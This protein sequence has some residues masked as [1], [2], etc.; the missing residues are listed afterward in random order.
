MGLYD[1]PE[2][3]RNLLNGF[4]QGAM[5]PAMGPVVGGAARMAA[6]YLQSGAA[7]AANMAGTLP[8]YMGMGVGDASSPAG[9]QGQ[10][11]ALPQAA[12]QAPA[13]APT[14][15]PPAPRT[16]QTMRIWNG[17][18]QTKATFNEAP[19]PY[20]QASPWWHISQLQDGGGRTLADPQSQGDIN[21]FVK[22]SI[23]EAQQQQNK[24][25][26]GNPHVPTTNAL[27]QALSRT[28]RYTG[29]YSPEDMQR[30]LQAQEKLLHGQAEQTKAEAAQTAAGKE[31]TAEERLIGGTYNTPG[32]S[33][34]ES[35]QLLK[36]IRAE[37]AAAKKGGG[38]ADTQTAPVLPGTGKGPPS[39]TNEEDINKLITD[40]PKQPTEESRKAILASAGAAPG[41]TFDIDSLLK[42]LPGNE[43]VTERGMSPLVT[44]LLNSTAVGG[45]DA[46][47]TAAQ[48]AMIRRMNALKLKQYGRFSLDDPRSVPFPAHNISPE[49]HHTLH[50]PA[51]DFTASEPALSAIIPG[52]SRITDRF[53]LWSPKTRQEY[54]SQLGPLNAILEELQRSSPRQ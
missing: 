48:T 1:D 38:N 25:E 17:P 45:R 41:G 11:P 16:S 33:P 46:L 28:A 52:A 3:Y 2:Y 10:A 7:S 8:Y 30:A 6:P 53:P 32:R 22:R 21:D 36:V 43:N 51:G 19:N 37:A 40:L 29:D 12:Q 49:T 44:A 15:P 50:G 39:G 23:Q 47:L 35:H 27:V 34:E 18:A 14:P 26:T 31:P 54:T 4:A 13:A 5:G 24:R 42:V 9:Q 20:G